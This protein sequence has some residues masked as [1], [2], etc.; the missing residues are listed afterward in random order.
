M[1]Y[2][3]FQPSD[4][5]LDSQKVVKPAWS[6]DTEILSTFYTPVIDNGFYVNVYKDNI[7]VNPLATPQFSI[8]YANISGSG[9]ISGSAYQTYDG[10]K[11]TKIS[12]SS[13]RQNILNSETDL[14]N[15]NATGG[16]S[17]DEIFVLSLSRDCYRESIQGGFNLRLKSG[18]NILSLTD[19]S[20]IDIVNNYIGNTRY[21]TI[22]SG[23][24]GVLASGSSIVN[25]TQGTYGIVLPDLGLFVLNPKALALSYVNKGIGLNITTTPTNATQR[26]ELKLFNMISA[27]QYFQVRSEETVTSKYYFCRLSNA[28]FNFTTNPSILDSS[29]NIFD[30]S[31]IDNPTTYVT[32]LGVYTDKMELVGVAKLSKPLK[33]TFIEDKIIKVKF[34][35]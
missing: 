28:D 17:S 24:N 19:D 16:I 1:T 7:S 26:N 8:S 15:F 21:Y 13:F 30:Q 27:G 22:I 25:T 33:K 6:N 29:G 4:S 20:K 10:T 5:T 18:S 9:N 12:Y 32:T 11:F 31:I 35:W 34:S 23:S 3:K 14:F 2:I